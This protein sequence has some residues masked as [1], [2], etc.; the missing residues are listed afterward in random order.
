M[1]FKKVTKVAWEYLLLTFGVFLYAFAWNAFMIPQGLSGGGLTGITT[2]IQYATNGLIPMSVSYLVINAA[3]IFV[4]A[5]ILG[6]VF[7]FKTLYCIGMSSLFLWL[8]PRIGWVV[9][10]SD[11]EDNLI[12]ALIGGTIA[13]FGIYL[14]FTKGGSTGGTDILAL[15]L[16]KFHDTSPGKV[17]MY[18]DFIIVGSILFLPG[19]GLSDVVYGY[20]FTIAFSKMLDVFLTGSTNSVQILIFTRMYNEV[21]DALINQDRGVTALNSIGW[22]TKQENKVLVVVA[23]KSQMNQITKTVKE[24]DPKAFISVGAVLGVYGERFEEI[25]TRPKKRPKAKKESEMLSKNGERSA[26]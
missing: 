7:G 24:I 20:I 10:L 11:I 4:G 13:A 23:R 14:V 9:N 2:I 5:F 21:G 26:L 6:P 3:L 8:L 17:F 16:S 19:H 1:E 12:N 15:V 25:K 22:Y 18:S